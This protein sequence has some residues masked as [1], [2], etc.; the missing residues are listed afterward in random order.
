[1]EVE[2]KTGELKVAETVTWRSS[3]PLIA[4]KARAKEPRAKSQSQES[5]LEPRAKA[6]A[7]KLESFKASDKMVF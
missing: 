3:E 1:M 7:R 4:H 2:R 6:R 5:E